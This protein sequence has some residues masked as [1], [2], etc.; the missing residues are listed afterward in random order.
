MSSWAAKHATPRQRAAHLPSPRHASPPITHPSR[1]SLALAVAAVYSPAEYRL[2]GGCVWDGGEAAMRMDQ[3]DEDVDVVAQDGER[4]ERAQRALTRYLQGQRV[5]E[6][7]AELAVSE[8][9]ARRWIRQALTSLAADERAEQATQLQ[10]A[11]ESQRAVASAAWEAYE[12]ER[13]LD[14]A[15]LRG[16]LDTVRR[17][18][19]RGRRLPA[20]TGGGADDDCPPIAIEEYQRPKRSEERRV[21]KECRSR[22]SPYH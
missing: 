4:D 18:A 8:T 10:R 21:G 3:P 1:G 12:R 2:R 16:E 5:A 14:E 13:Q 9:T 17:R 6:V 19:M 7:A 15:L 20:T 22:W 11:I